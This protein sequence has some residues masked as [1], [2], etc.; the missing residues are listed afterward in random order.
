MSYG[1]GIELLSPAIIRS[2]YLAEVRKTLGTYH[3]YTRQ[4]VLI[5][6]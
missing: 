1:D 2:E 5:L 3:D 6:G 4:S